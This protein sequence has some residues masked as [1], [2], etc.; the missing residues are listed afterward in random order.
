MADKNIP[1][2]PRIR[3]EVF[4][5]STN[6]SLVKPIKES[7]VNK[8]LMAGYIPCYM[9]SFTRI[10]DM[11]KNEE[12]VK[13]NIKRSD[14]FVLIV[15]ADYGSV[16]NGKSWIDFEYQYA[17]YLKKPI[18][19]LLLNEKSAYKLRRSSQIDK[20]DKEYETFRDQLDT[21][22]SIIFDYH[23]DSKK[24]NLSQ[25]NY[26]KY[27]QELN[28]CEK[29]LNGKGGWYRSN[30]EL[31]ADIIAKFVSNTTL[32]DRTKKDSDLKEA[33]AQAFLVCYLQKLINN[34]YLKFFFESGSSTAFVAKKFVDLFSPNSYRTQGAETQ[35]IVRGV[36]T[37]KIIAGEN[38]KIQIKTNNSLAHFY[39]F[40]SLPLNKL[41]LYPQGNPQNRYG[42]TLGDLER[43]IDP[44]PNSEEYIGQNANNILRE[45]TTEFNKDYVGSGSK[46]TGK[47]MIFMAASGVEI[48]ADKLGGPHV[49]SY[50]NMLFKKALLASKCPT[51]MFLDQEKL[52]KEKEYRHLVCDDELTWSGICNGRIKSPFAGS[53]KSFN[54]PFAIAIGLRPDVPN[55]KADAPNANKEDTK[56]EIKKI[57][58]GLDL[59]V[60][61]EVRVGEEEGK[62]DEDI[63]V[64]VAAN[65]YFKEIVYQT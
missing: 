2:E 48:G 7:V 19:R 17:T 1:P 5:S 56:K 64:L 59:E 21:Y 41:C 15:G 34:N 32:I 60:V 14:I 3:Y 62:V 6:H 58:K 40:W 12:E 65:K 44:T 20:F 49:G 26:G 4:I 46:K 33:V 31:V 27:T 36:E 35:K 23:D 9:E 45:F 28:E 54:K 47:G 25:N 57:F 16:I 13:R 37:P 18:I 10:G 53:K 63:L 11:P 24:F 43:V 55:A 30:S 50:K 51:V 61:E 52:P 8:T 39:F 38:L 22:Y 29:R 42:A